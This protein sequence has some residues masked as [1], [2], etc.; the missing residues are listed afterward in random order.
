M[1]PDVVDVERA[2]ISAALRSSARSIDALFAELPEVDASD[3]IDRRHATYFVARCM[4]ARRGELPTLDALVGAIGALMLP[5][6]APVPEHIAELLRVVPRLPAAQAAARL[7]A[8]SDERRRV[9][10]ELRR[11]VEVPE[12]LSPASD[13]V[14]ARPT[15]ALV[16]SNAPASLSERLA[17]ATLR[18]WCDDPARLAPPEAFVA[19]FLHRG[20]TTMLYAREKRGKSTLVASLV[21]QLSRTGL[22]VLWLALDE[23]LGDVVRRL[24]HLGAD[25]DRVVVPDVADAAGDLLAALQLTEGDA[26]DLVVVDALAGLLAR[27]V[28]RVSDSGQIERALRPFIAATH[29]SRAA[30]LLIHHA[31]KGNE[32]R[33]STAIG[34][35]VDIIAELRAPRSKGGDST[36]RTLHVLGRLGPR[37]IPL[38]FDPVTAAYA[39]DAPPED[40]R[41]AAPPAP[42]APSAPPA[43]ARPVPDRVLDA[44]RQHPGATARQVCRVARARHETVRAA[45]DDLMRDGRVVNLGS[46]ERPRY[47]EAPR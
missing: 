5:A 13:V 9:P 39:L 31:S 23:A 14:P 29:R 10:P 43:P 41:A 1:A 44:V 42:P 30:T 45:L 21:A 7:V 32:Y 36:R 33:D 16:R 8:V 18:A 24:V 12:V 4:L 46:E 38:T 11:Q 2:V 15:L 25:V 35:A 28:E 47:A 40:A 17:G 19:R 6:A 34:A 26:F 20:R 3:F 22:R 27:A 37:D